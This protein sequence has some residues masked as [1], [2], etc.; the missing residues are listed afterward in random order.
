MGCIYLIRNTVNGKCYVGLTT[1]H[2]HQ[3]IHNHLSGHGN[4]LI[5]ND[6]Q[7][8]GKDAFEYKILHE[9]VTPELLPQ[10]EVQAIEEY[11]AFHPNGY[12]LQTG[13]S[14]GYVA[15][16]ESLTRMSDSLR[17][18]NAPNKGIPHSAET[19][20]KI[21]RKAKGRSRGPHSEKTKQKIAMGNT[22]KVFTQERRNNIGRALK[23]KPSHNRSPEYETAK[24][25]FYSFP[26]DTP[27]KQKRQCLIEKFPERGQS[28]IY[29]WT[30]KWHQE[31]TGSPPTLKNGKK[32]EYEEAKEFFHSFSS[33]ISLQEKRESLY[34]K[35]PSVGRKTLQS[36]IREWH[37]ELT[38]SP[39]P[40][41][42]NK[43][44]KTGKT[45][46]P[47]ANRSPFFTPAHNFF[48]SLSS[49]MPL[50]EKRKLLREKFT[51]VNPKRIQQWT[52]QWQSE[53][54]DN[55]QGDLLND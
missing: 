39:P 20:K 40:R 22:G 1:R 21:S 7:K 24:D 29:K 48:T 52:A 50:S 25:F 14:R 13:G 43:G 16:E 32:L 11:N 46:K 19:R 38:G 30:Y 51:E 42:W 26:S 37:I 9:G 2:S 53:L 55:N 34:A 23:G 33:D 44:I 49:D 15:S 35:F 36:W 6:V 10:F 45:G 27:L 41:G 3:R 4:R 28:T 18:R 54:E 31:L 17:G 12:N 8:Y 5:Y 47:A